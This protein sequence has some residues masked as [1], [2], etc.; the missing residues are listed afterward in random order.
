MRG[1]TASLSFISL[2]RVRFSLMHQ[3]V[4]MLFVS[5]QHSLLD[6]TVSVW[7]TIHQTRHQ[8]P[9]LRKEKG[10]E[11]APVLKKK[12]II[13]PVN[14]WCLN[15]SPDEYNKVE[16]AYLHFKKHLLI[17]SLL[18]THSFSVTYVLD[19]CFF[20]SQ[21][22]PRSCNTQNH[23]SQSRLC[24]SSICCVHFNTWFTA[25]SSNDQTRPLS[26][27][28]GVLP[29]FQKTLGCCTTNKTGW[30]FWQLKTIQRQY[31]SCFTSTFL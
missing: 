5:A 10:S 14:W 26:S 1:F 15:C 19:K 13:H 21:D 22:D 16:R 25:A 20:R 30:P 8:R 2:T 27:C 18:Y 12:S 3:P 7:L 29:L 23:L 6:V 24:W 17:Y 9:E 4:K 28:C 31:T 11:F